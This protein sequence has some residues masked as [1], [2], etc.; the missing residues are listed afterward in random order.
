[1]I[2]FSED[3]LHNPPVRLMMINWHQHLGHS[4]E[5]NILTPL[6][7]CPIPGTG[8]LADVGNNLQQFR[9][10]ERRAEVNTT[11]LEAGLCPEDL[12]KN[13]NHLHNREREGMCVCQHNI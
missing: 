3:E 10:K 1:M 9:S 11:T 7:H 6:T 4:G 8:V 13:V 5:L 12:Q 2:G